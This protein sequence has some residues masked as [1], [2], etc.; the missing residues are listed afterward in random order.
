MYHV[1]KF[2]FSSTVLKDLS[3]QCFMREFFT[4][5][6]A[7]FSTNF[8]GDLTFT[9]F[10][11]FL[12]SMAMK[13]NERF[14]WIACGYI[15]SHVLVM[16]VLGNYIIF[17]SSSLINLRNISYFIIKGALELFMKKYTHLHTHFFG[18]IFQIKI[19]LKYGP[20][21]S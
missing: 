7:T 14:L 18:N 11:D 3:L 8:I 17:S 1:H 16:Y 19:P 12:I 15:R 10:K 13:W 21:Y 2:W 5:L 6:S 4:S 9:M 20:K